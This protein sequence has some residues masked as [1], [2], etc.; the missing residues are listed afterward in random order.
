MASPQAG[1]R[2]LQA[3]L[4]NPANA[5]LLPDG[6]DGGG[7][8]RRTAQRLSPTATALVL[9]VHEK[10]Y[11]RKKK[12]RRHGIIPEALSGKSNNNAT[13]AYETTAKRHSPN[14]AALVLQIIRHTT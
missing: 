12:T 11:A 4:L 6:A 7:R 8:C 1:V 13:R 10:Q 2:A 9:Q 14:V 5:A 3:A